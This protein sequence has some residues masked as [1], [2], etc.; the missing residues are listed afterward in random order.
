[1]KKH[2]SLP[3]IR[4]VDSFKHTRKVK[5]VHHV[6]SGLAVLKLGKLSVV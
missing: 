4:A 6:W 1:V 2:S 3:F 5:K